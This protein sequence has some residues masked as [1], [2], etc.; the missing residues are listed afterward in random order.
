MKT[1]FLNDNAEKNIFEEGLKHLRSRSEDLKY[2]SVFAGCE[3][4]TDFIDTLKNQDFDLDEIKDSISKYEDLSKWSE[5]GLSFDFVE[6]GTFDDRKEAYYRYQFSWGGPTEEIRIYEDGEIVFVYLNWYCGVGFD[7][8]GEDQ[9]IWLVDWFRGRA[10]IDWD[11]I[12]YE[13]KHTEEM[14]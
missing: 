10:S 13:Q 5:Y 2:F 11:N 9:F 1:T 6:I 3:D 14:G 8:S 4:E 12:P 7:V